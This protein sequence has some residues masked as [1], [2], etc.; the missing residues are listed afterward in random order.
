MTFWRLWGCRFRPFAQSMLLVK[1]YVGV[2]NAQPPDKVV[3]FGFFGPVLMAGPIAEYEE[4]ENS[5][6]AGASESPDDVLIG[7]ARIGLGL[8]KIWGIAWILEPSQAIFKAQD[9]NTVAVFWF[10]L[11]VFTWYFYINFSGYADC[12]IGIARLGG[13]RLKENFANPDFQTSPQAFW[14]SWH[15]SLTRF[16]QRNVFVPL[17]GRSPRNP[18]LGNLW[19]H[20]GHRPVAQ[21][22]WKYVAVR[23]LP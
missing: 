13:V 16:A 10:S 12:A 11:I 5:K 17:G 15:M 14:A 6:R 20:A 19:H 18:V 4:F 1:S 21:P 7:A 9:T 8:I 23:T 2:L 3:A 22:Q